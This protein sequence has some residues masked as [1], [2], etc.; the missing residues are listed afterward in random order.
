MTREKLWKKIDVGTLDNPPS[1]LR[2]EDVCYY[3][4]EYVSKGRYDA[5]QGNQ[6]ISNL[7]IPA[8]AKGTKRWDHKIVAVN[9]FALEL[10]SLLI[11]GANLMFIPSSKTKRSN[12]YD[13]RWDMLK[14]RMVCYHQE[15][16]FKFHEPFRLRSDCQASHQGGR[17]SPKSVEESIAFDGFESGQVPTQIVIVD[18][19]ITS[20]SHFRALSN[21]LIENCPGMLVYGVFWTRTVQPE[22]DARAVFAG[23]FDD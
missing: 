2:A 23:L 6:L 16:R 1:Q 13:P 22:F 21:I 10:S 12:D 8:S 17:R 7:K 5:S 3:S 19:V 20:G 14:S 15:K 11:D 18:D 4:R 9:R